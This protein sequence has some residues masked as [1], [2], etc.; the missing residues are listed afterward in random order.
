MPAHALV[1][2]IRTGTASPIDRLRTSGSVSDVAHPE[3][4]MDSV[5]RAESISKSFGPI[6]V[7]SGI[8]LDLKPGEVH[9]V[10]GENG[11]GKSTLMRILSGHLAPTKGSSS[12]ER[13]AG[14]VL[15]AGGCRKPGHRSRAP[16]DPARAGSDRRAE[17]V[18]RPRDPALRLRRRHGHARAGATPSCVELGTGIDP[19]RQVQPPLH[20]RPAARADRPRAC[21]C[22]TRS[23]PSTSRRPFSRPSRPK[24]CSR[25]SASCAPRAWP[26][27]TSPTA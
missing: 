26:S 25:S 22:R 2:L 11:A 23:S 24:A 14:H 10:I 1:Q 18:P 9:A 19:D 7:L 15:R 4:F 3:Q 27:S 6:E 5:L 17:P 8:S 12:S 21:W 13:P 20:R 16:G